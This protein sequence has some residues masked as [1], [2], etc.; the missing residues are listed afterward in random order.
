METDPELNNAKIKAVKG[1]IQKNIK[2]DK[3]TGIKKKIPKKTK[4]SAK[5]SPNPPPHVETVDLKKV[6]I[7]MSHK[8][9]SPQPP[10][11]PISTILCIPAYN[12]EKEIGPLII[13]SKP[14]FDRILVCDDGSDDL[15]EQIAT[16]LGATVI[17]HETSSGRI[18][19]IRTLL[20]RSLELEPAI[21]IV[22]DVNPR[23]QPTE[24]QKVLSPIKSK[25]VDVVFGAQPT[26]ATNPVENIDEDDLK[27]IFMAF[28]QKSLKAFL[29]APSEVLERHSRI[30]GVASSNGLNLRE[31]PI[32]L[33]RVPLKIDE[34]E[35]QTLEVPQTNTEIKQQSP[36]QDKLNGQGIAQNFIQLISTKSFF[37]FGIS[38]LL[39][40]AIGIYAGAYLLTT[41]LNLHFLSLPAAFIMIIGVISGLFLVTTSIIL[42]S[43]S[44]FFKEG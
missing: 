34:H 17:R 42:A 24:I 18:A 1:K 5:A 6:T 3:K 32:E 19:T 2:P 20:E 9:P 41:F 4:D 13:K 40:L 10:I 16:G 38:G 25:E 28:S 22:M 35:T 8:I 36:T 43:F 7:N 12:E 31:V 26:D 30:L 39:P 44:A 15:M 21:T 33:Q 27:S 11:K 23:L 37:F 14:Y 29:S